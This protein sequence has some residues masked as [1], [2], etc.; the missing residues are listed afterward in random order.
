M[1]TILVVIAMIAIFFGS[2]AVLPLLPISLLKRVWDFQ[3]PGFTGEMEKAMATKLQRLG[4]AKAGVEVSFTVAGCVYFPGMDLISMSV[5]DC[6]ETAQKFNMSFEQTLLQV[7]APECG[8]T[9]QEERLLAPL[10]RWSV[11]LEC[12]ADAWKRAESFTAINPAMAAAKLATYHMAAATAGY[13][14]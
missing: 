8:H 13:K 9:H 1:I 5:E 14:G 3:L 11:V 6:M 7:F 4:W 12:E 10:R 2:F